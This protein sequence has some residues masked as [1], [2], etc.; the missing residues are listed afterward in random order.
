MN[1]QPPK[2]A[3]RFL[4]WYCSPDFMEEILGD[5]LEL[6]E[7]RLRI[8]GE[9]SADLKFV[10]DVIRFFRLSNL[11]K[12]D[13]YVPGSRNGLWGLNLK[14]AWRQAS[15][16]KLIFS[17]K[18]LGLSI[19]MAFSLLLTSYV[20][21]ELTFDQFHLNHDHIYRITSYVNFQ[22][23]ITHYAVTPLPIGNEMV[24]Q[25][26]EVDR[27]FR[28]MYEDKPIY[29]VKDNV[30][31]NEVTLAVD[32][33]FLNV[34]TFEFLHGNTSALNEPN[35]IVI[36]ESVA[37]KFFDDEN[38]MGQTIE[39]GK[40]ILLEVSGVIKDVPA[41]SHLQFDALTSWDTFNRYDH[42]GN[43]NAYTY[44]LLKEGASLE[45]V[46]KKMPSVLATF[47]DLVA[48][49][50]KATYE[51]RF[52]KI[53][54]IHFSETLDEDIVEKKSKSN[55]MILMAVILLFAIMGIINYL[56]LSLA[57]LTTNLKKIGIIRIFGGQ[58]DGHKK[59]LISETILTLLIVLPITLLIL[60]AGFFL[61]EKYLSIR[62]GEQVVFSKIFVSVAGVFLLSLLVSTRINSYFLSKASQVTDSLKGKLSVMKGGIPIRKLLVGVQLSFS[63]I[64]IALVLI[65]VDQFHFIQEADKG[66]DINN[67][68]VIKFRAGSHTQKEDFNVRLSKLTGVA[69]VGTSSYYP[70]IIE[71]KDVFQIES[72]T[73]TTELLVT[74]MDC[75]YDY[76][77][78]MGISILEGRNFDRGSV[79]DL[80]GA[81]LI[82]ETAAKQFGWK[83][84][85]GKK[86]VGPIRSDGREGEVIGV[87]R[88]FNFASMYSKIEPLIIFLTNEDWGIHYAYIK[89]HPLG[90]PDL[91]AA[92]EKEYKAQWPEYPFEW[93][94]LDS[95]YMTL[96][97]KDNEIKS[98]F[99]IGLF[100]SI[101]ISCLGVFSISA[102]LATLRTKEMGIRKVVGA[103]TIQLFTLHIKS[104]LPFLLIALLI[105]W[106]VIWYLSGQWLQNFAYHVE[107]NVW[108]FILPGMLIL[109]ITLLTSG[110]HGI[111]NALIN[112]LASLNHE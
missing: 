53:Q 16:N 87:V 76:F 62:I 4:Q 33:S 15:R 74:M 66:F 17:I 78:V 75:S 88:D 5:A 86:I 47:H 95:K 59:I 97:E 34:L 72:E 107:L 23:H 70:G 101:L 67:R 36:T 14:I 90:S 60:Y 111:K 30:F 2:W 24:E 3:L 100:I 109:F 41:N 31:N 57:E 35:K 81:Y 22:D 94:Y 55:L 103:S 27:Y 65:I 25:V 68:L 84:P 82:N 96:Y 48:R 10:W 105:A 19:G 32:S 91:I 89:T 77:D 51:P 37:R 52:E 39:F 46:K 49:E 9:R 26:P 99:E 98:I 106:P 42:W 7:E 63:I 11:K 69:Q 29:R 43:L 8:E 54:D 102:L 21:N 58:T 6:Y 45:A 44:I 64:M 104:F 38:P 79:T 40:D 108:H 73:G 92:I 13:Q 112:P 56:N 85:I 18:A 1:T 83:N 61:A 93:E 20:V 110:Y 80:K 28:F 50:Y 12:S 71:T